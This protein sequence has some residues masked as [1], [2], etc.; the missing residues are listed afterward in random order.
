VQRLLDA[1]RFAIGKA[2]GSAGS[3]HTTGA[4]AV[5]TDC[6]DDP[7]RSVHQQTKH[8]ADAGLSTVLATVCISGWYLVRTKR[9]QRFVA[10][11]CQAP[12][13]VT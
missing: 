8:T 12:K 10:S 6:T 5:R 11:Q 3:K 9:T 13:A 7:K 4:P 2:G 1:T